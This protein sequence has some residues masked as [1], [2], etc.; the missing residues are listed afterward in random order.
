MQFI[1]GAIGTM[2]S[3]LSNR[4]SRRY[5]QYSVLTWRIPLSILFNRFMG[6]SPLHSST[7]PPNINFQFYLIDS[8]DASSPWRLSASQESLSILFNR[9]AYLEWHD[10]V[11][12]VEAPFQFYLID[13][14]RRKGA[15]C[16]SSREAHF[17]FY[18][19]DS[20]CPGDAP[21]GEQPV[22]FNSI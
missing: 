19:I 14:G 4:F 21:P 15:C 10:Y 20:Y 13:S 1:T 12:A 16:E 22:P 3:I 18:L 17:Q 6:L 7:W 11:V 9:F 8:S 5:K 2:L